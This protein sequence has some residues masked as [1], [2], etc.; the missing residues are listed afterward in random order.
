VKDDFS[1]GVLLHGFFIVT[2]IAIGIIIIITIII[3]SQNIT[4]ISSNLSS[5]FTAKRGTC[6]LAAF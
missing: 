2:L 5:Q 3:I 4:I 1:T 6:Q